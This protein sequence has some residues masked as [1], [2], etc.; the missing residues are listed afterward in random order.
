MLYRVVGAAAVVAALLVGGSVDALAAAK[1]S[2]DAGRVAC[3]D[4]CNGHNKTDKS[5]IQCENQ[6]DRYY[7]PGGGTRIQ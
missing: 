4:W 6:C 2:K 5:I 1:S 3:Y 7:L